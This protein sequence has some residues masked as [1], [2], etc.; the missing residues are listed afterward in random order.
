MIVGVLDQV[1]V[2][3]TMKLDIYIVKDVKEGIIQLHELSKKK[4][5]NK[6]CECRRFGLK[7]K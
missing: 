6:M 1:D 5:Q 3:L 7:E 4:G 2:G